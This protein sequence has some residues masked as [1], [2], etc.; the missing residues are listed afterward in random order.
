MSRSAEKQQYPDEGSRSWNQYNE[1]QPATKS[2]SPPSSGSNS[3]AYYSRENRAISPSNFQ[4]YDERG[5]HSPPLIPEEIRKLSSIT[6]NSFEERRHSPKPTLLP[7][8]ILRGAA[9]NSRSL[10]R[11]YGNERER[12]FAPGDD[13]SNLSSQ[14]PD[15][16]GVDQTPIKKPSQYGDIKQ[17]R[18]SQDSNIS[19]YRDAVNQAASNQFPGNVRNDDWKVVAAKQT[20]PA[21]DD[22]LLSRQKL[23]EVIKSIPV[24]V[25]AMID[26]MFFFSGSCEGCKPLSHSRS[27]PSPRSPFPHFRPQ[28]LGFDR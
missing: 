19:N 28:S 15:Y 17:K 11:S 2:P 4:N 14:T 26:F 1:Y 6:Q 27:L 20:D 5:R 10:E 7:Q 3:P 21:E 23:A 18:S 16:G 24:I 9:P 12:S 8:E 13:M 25:S 22:D